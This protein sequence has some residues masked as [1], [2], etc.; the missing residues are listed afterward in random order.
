[1]N[2]KILFKEIPL[3]P[4]KFHVDVWVCNDI[5]LLPEKFHK[6]YGASIEYYKDALINNSV[7]SLISTPDAELQS[8]QRIVVTIDNFDTNV[9][10]HESNHVVYHLS[11]HCN[12]ETDYNS[13]EWHSYMLEYIFE[14][15]IDEKSYISI[16]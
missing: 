4:T 5:T 12:L 1:M 10:V 16:V 7:V 15:C 8:T 3:L 14:Q 13:Q 6:R 9:I 2:G 11:K